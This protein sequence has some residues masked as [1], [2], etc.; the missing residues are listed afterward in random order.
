M[1]ASVLQHGVC[2]RNRLE[3]PIAVKNNML[4][5]WHRHLRNELA[6]EHLY[7]VRPRQR[8]TSYGERRATTS[9]ASMRWGRGLA[10]FVSFTEK[11]AAKSSP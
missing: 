11:K 7:P 6:T 9:R 8:S 3:I 2:I 1:L 5:A 4:L 10:V